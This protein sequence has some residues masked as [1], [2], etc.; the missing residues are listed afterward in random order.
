VGCGAAEVPE[1]EAAALSLLAGTSTSTTTAGSSTG[2]GSIR[3]LR[4][5]KGGNLT[6]WFNLVDGNFLPVFGK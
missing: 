5:R 1:E 4:D 6:N 3:L 2:T